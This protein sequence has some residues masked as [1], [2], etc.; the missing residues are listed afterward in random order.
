MPHVHQNSL[1]KSDNSHFPNFSR[2]RVIREIECKNQIGI[3]PSFHETA[4]ST[5]QR[6]PPHS[7]FQNEALTLVDH[8]IFYWNYDYALWSLWIYNFRW[9]ATMNWLI[10]WKVSA[11]ECECAL[12]NSSNRFLTRICKYNLKRSPTIKLL[13]NSITSLGSRGPQGWWRLGACHDW[14]LGKIHVSG[15]AFMRAVQQGLPF[16][17]FEVNF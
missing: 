17:A 13:L 9:L 16:A 1:Q 7:D 11:S 8:L 15:A 3:A 4:I 12:I 14:S 2:Y 5:T 6:F 10:K